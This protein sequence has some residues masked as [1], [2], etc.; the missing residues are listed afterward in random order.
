M[1]IVVLLVISALVSGSETAFFSLSPSDMGEAKKLR[2]P[3]D[4]IILKLLER[5]ERLF[6]AMVIARC[7]IDISIVILCI[8]FFDTIA[9]P[10]GSGWRLVV[11][12]AVIV[13]L[14]LLFGAVIPKIFSARA[15]L[16]FV[17]RMARPLLGLERIMAPFSCLLVRSSDAINERLARRK[18]PGIS[19]DEL[20]DA[21]EITQDNSEQQKQMLSGI[22][23]FV[24]TE[25]AE[26]MKLR[27]DVVALDITADFA[28]VKKTILDSGFS[29][30]P[31]FE[32]NI[33]TVKGVLY[34]KDMTPFIGRADDFAWQAYIRKPYFVP[35]HK[36][37][38]DLLEEFQAHKVHIAIVVDEYGATQGLVSLEDIL[39]E[40]VGEISDESDPE[41]PTF[42]K[43]IDDHTYIFEGKTHI[44]DFL[45]AVGAGENYFEEEGADVETL[46]GL[47]LELRHD[48]LR[49]GD[50]VRSH[51]MKFTVTALDGRRIDK[52]RVEIEE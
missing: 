38:N 12:A 15:P 2:K 51:G 17:R 45:E 46:A 6:S 52:V 42:Y 11:E 9:R 23:S 36:K 29:R 14:L 3:S 35:E 47:L 18:T 30:I 16:R 20:S 25:V 26:I 39:E 24:N 34:V 50:S 31:V 19:I 43:K 4:N 32:E 41:Q 33:D 49:K 28:A 8:R 27:P 10:G 13:L 44:A 48:F 22:V 7:L 5:Q 1:V 21:I 37:I 40:I